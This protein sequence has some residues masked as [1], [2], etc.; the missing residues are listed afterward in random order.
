[1]AYY[2]RVRQQYLVSPSHPSTAQART[3]MVT[4][5]PQE[6]LT[7]SALTRLFNHLPGGVRN[8]WISRDL[9]DMPK[10]YN[11]ELEAYQMLESA[12]TSLLKKAMKRNRKRLRNPA[13]FGDGR[14][15]VS[16]AELTDLISDPETRGTL[17]EELVSKHKRPSHRLPLFSWMPFSIPLLGKKV[18]TIQRTCKRIHE[19][20]AELAQRREILAVDITRTTAAEA[21]TTSRTHN[22]LHN[23]DAEKSNIVIPAVPDFPLFRIHAVVDFSDLTYPPANGA[24]ILFNK[25]IAAHIAAQTLTHHEPYCMPNSLKYVETT[26]EDVIW[27]NLALNPYRRR[28]RLVLSWTVAI[29]LMIVWTSPGKPRLIYRNQYLELNRT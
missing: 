17:M 22:I 13:N 2:V 11:E 18:D 4:G 10:L 9:G 1:M 25:Q 7:E 15:I 20:N 8:V 26:P 16:N 23:I 3:V 14:D 29:A 12:A 19:L 27:K 5:I 28:L 6:F 24:F 21:Q